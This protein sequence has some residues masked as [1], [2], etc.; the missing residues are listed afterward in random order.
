MS[1]NDAHPVVMAATWSVLNLFI[2]GSTGMLILHLGILWWALY[3]LANTSTF[4]RY[5]RIVMT[6][7]LLPFICNFEGT[8]WKDVEMAISLVLA[9]SYIVDKENNRIQLGK[10]SIIF[11]SLFFAYAVRHNA[12]LAVIPLAVYWASKFGRNVIKVASLS[13]LTIIVFQVANN[14]LSYQILHAQRINLTNVMK[15]DDIYVASLAEHRSLIPDLSFQSIVNCENY[16]LGGTN[17]QQKYWCLSQTSEYANHDPLKVDLNNIWL[18]SISNH[19]WLILK[20]RLAVY[21]NFLRGAHLAPYEIWPEASSNPT[22]HLYFNNNAGYELMHA[23]VIGSA[24]WFSFLF[25]PYFWLSLSIAIVLAVPLLKIGSH[26]GVIFSLG[27]SSFLYIAGYVVANSAADFRYIYWSIF[28]NLLSLILIV[29]QLRERRL[30]KHWQTYF[31]LGAL[32]TILAISYFLG[33]IVN[34]NFNRI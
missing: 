19:P 28:A 29:P 33:D 21:S 27:I 4:G 31:F 6:I 30:I 10:D 13:M 25:E 15:L 20:Y 12:I 18:K 23:Y 2:H 8:I 26:R 5:P 22:L 7:G 3:K 34:F 32:V 9:F 14:A 16:M 24:R 11:L 17:L 1:F